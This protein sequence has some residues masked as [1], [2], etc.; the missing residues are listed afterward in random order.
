MLCIFSVMTSYDSL[1]STIAS[2]RN[3]VPGRPA[4][5]SSRI[6]NPSARTGPNTTKPT[7]RTT[8]SSTAPTT[9]PLPPPPRRP[10]R[11]R[12]LMPQERP[13]QCAVASSS[14]RVRTAAES[15]PSS[16]SGGLARLF[17]R[18]PRGSGDGGKNAEEARIEGSG[19]MLTRVSLRVWED[20]AWLTILL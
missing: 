10:P 12:Q 3:G 8:R 5:S 11:R 14:T 15:A 19:P 7:T 9:T 16:I 6:R 18:D 2:C 13:F 4:R 17:P 1:Q 20:Y